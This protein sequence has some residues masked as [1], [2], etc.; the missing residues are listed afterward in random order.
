MSKFIT[1]FAVAK[2]C[3]IMESNRKARNRAIKRLLCRE[4]K[5]EVWVLF[6]LA[7]SM[8]Y[9]LVSNLLMHCS[10]LPLPATILDIMVSVD[11]TLRNCCYG[12]I[13]G[14]T[15]YLL[16]DLYKNVYKKVDLY[17]EMY[18]Y[19]Y[20][21]WLKTY[22]MVL[23]INDHK[24]DE[25]Q[26]NEELHASIILNLCGPSEKEPSL[27]SKSEIL[28]SEVHLLNAFWPDILKDKEK[29]LNVYGDIITR[30]EYSKLNDK[31]LD[32][33]VERLKVYEPNDEEIISGMMI[34][35]RDYDIQRAIYLI[36]NFKAD[37]AAMVNKYSLY[38]YNEERGIRKDAF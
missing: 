37:L 5:K 15:F 12:L 3:R 8:V 18:P 13:T 4:A 14:I 29:F 36:L 35:I 25:L 20:K 19:L 31:E 2:V 33:S 26:T 30:E 38:Y 23:A 7:F 34:T 24:L 21:L 32:T 9:A 11:E 6:I 10:P 17:N 22:Q 1:T 28:A 16:N 27:R